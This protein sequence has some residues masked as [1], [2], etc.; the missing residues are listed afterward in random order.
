MVAI[1]TTELR[2]NFKKYFDIA[3][4]ERV[5]VHYGKT[6]AYEIIPTQ[7]ESENDPYFSNPKLLAALKEAEEDIAAGRF[8]EI[9]DPKNL[10]DS[11][12]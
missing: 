7:K 5:V 1:T 3:Q 10:W 6:Q 9:K 11:I 4:K 2:K 8:T 12:K